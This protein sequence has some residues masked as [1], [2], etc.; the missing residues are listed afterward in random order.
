MCLLLDLTTFKNTLW[1]CKQTQFGLQATFLTK[2]IQNTLY[3]S[4]RSNKSV[5]YSTCYTS[6]NICK[7]LNLHCWHSSLLCGFPL[8]SWNLNCRIY[9]VTKIYYK[10]WKYKNATFTC[11][12]KT[13]PPLCNS[14]AMSTEVYTHQ[15]LYITF[16][17]CHIHLKQCSGRYCVAL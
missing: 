12:V 1:S 14:S 11:P 10:I 4:W 5:V 17:L 13:V 15:Y 8:W 6:Y 2:L 16:F 7:H 3:M 9:I